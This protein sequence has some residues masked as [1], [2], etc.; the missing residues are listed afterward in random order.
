MS[1]I[2]I[3]RQKTEFDLI[4]YVQ[5]AMLTFT[6]TATSDLRQPDRPTKDSLE[7]S[8]RLT[9]RWRYTYGRKYYADVNR[10]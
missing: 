6:K 2:V 10:F 9:L 7:V 3:R 4:G 1:Y 5:W 8:V